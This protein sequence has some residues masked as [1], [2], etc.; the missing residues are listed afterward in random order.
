MGHVL[1]A[2]FRVLEDSSVRVMHGHRRTNQR[3][4][5]QDAAIFIV[6]GRSGRAMDGLCGHAG[7][8][9]CPYCS[10]VQSESTCDEV[11]PGVSPV[12]GDK[13]GH[14]KVEQS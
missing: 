7:S 1:A 9:P 4:R 10:E 11:Q 14:H 8:G 6:H 13:A 2:Q 5:L 3:R 12:V